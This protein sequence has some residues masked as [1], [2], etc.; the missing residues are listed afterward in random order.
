LL[1]VKKGAPLLE[2]NRVALTYHSAPVE[3]RRSLVDTSEHEYFS[4]LGKAER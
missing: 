1:G 2:I 3:L 4:D